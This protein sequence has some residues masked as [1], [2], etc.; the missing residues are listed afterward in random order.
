MNASAKAKVLDVILGAAD[1][2]PIDVRAI[3]RVDGGP[4][5]SIS[6]AA[7]LP[8]ADRHPDL[9]WMVS[10]HLSLDGEG[11]D[12]VSCIGDRMA[13]VVSKSFPGLDIMGDAER[14]KWVLASR[15]A[16]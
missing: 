12:V 8:V 15:V 1:I 11:A 7:T 16:P 9:S 5:T 6:I 3:R 13:K 14:V 10:C 4:I 2:G